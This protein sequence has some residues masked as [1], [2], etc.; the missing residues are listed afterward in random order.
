MA[1]QRN[2]YVCQRDDGPKLIGFQDRRHWH[3]WETVEELAAYC[4]PER[5]EQ[6]QPVVTYIGPDAPQWRERPTCRGFWLDSR[7]EPWNFHTSLADDDVSSAW[8]PWFGP[9]PAIP[10][11]PEVL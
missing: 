3:T 9:I 7:Y 8:G 5:P 1:E 11:A 6:I 4:R 10:P 2:G